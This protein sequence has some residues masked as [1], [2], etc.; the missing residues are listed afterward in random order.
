MGISCMMDSFF[1]AVI[2][3]HSRQFVNSALQ[4]PEKALG[5][6]AKSFFFLPKPLSKCTKMGIRFWEG[7]AKR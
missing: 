7:G 5:K 6:A 4:N 3:P 1:S 2:V